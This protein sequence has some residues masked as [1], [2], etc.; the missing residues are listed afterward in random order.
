MN[1]D[2]DGE[3]MVMLNENSVDARQSKDDTL[4][5]IT[6]FGSVPAVVTPG[7]ICDE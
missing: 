7:F 3:L 4:V 1:P 6:S 5:T 2:E